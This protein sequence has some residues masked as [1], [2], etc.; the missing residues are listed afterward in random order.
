[1][2]TMKNLSKGLVGGRA[3]DAAAKVG[4]VT[5]ALIA[6]AM[7]RRTRAPGV[8]PGTAAAPRNTRS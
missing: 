2:S 4:A 1:M 3:Q 5:P 6:G 7:N 8:V